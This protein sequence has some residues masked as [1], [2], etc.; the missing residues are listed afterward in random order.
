LFEIKQGETSMKRFRAISLLFVFFMLVSLQ[1]AEPLG[2]QSVSSKKLNL[3][4]QKIRSFIDA[5]MKIWGTPGAAVGIVKD[6][7]VILAEGFGKR[8]VEKNLP[9]TAKTRFI[10]GSTTKAF[11]TMAMGILVD[12][13]KLDWDKPVVQ[14]I[15]QFKLMNEY[16]TLHVTP[17]DLATHRT[18]LPR[19]DM[20]WANS[21]FSL[22]ELVESLQYL[23]PSRDFRT[24][25][26][27]NNLMYIAAGYLVGQVSGSSWEDFVR[28]RIFKPLAMMDSGCTVPELT[29][30]AEYSF[31][32]GREKDKLKVLPF[33][34]PTD[35]L[36]YGARASGSI[37]TTAEDM[38]KWMLLHLNNGASGGK[39][40]ISKANLL[41][42]HTPQIPMPWRLTEKSEAMFPSYGLGW[43]I[44]SYR[45]HYRVH[46]GGA[47]MGFFSYVSLFPYENLGIVVQVN[48]GGALPTIV[49]NYASDVLLR[50]EALDWNK[51]A[52]DQMKAAAAP[53]EKRIEGTSPAHKMEDYAGEYIHPAYGLLKVDVAGNK[54]LASFHGRSSPLEHWHFETFQIAESD[55]G[56]TKLT[57]QTNALGDV[58]S[59]SAPLES[60]VKEIVFQRSQQRK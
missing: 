6:G 26:Q 9:V 49:A 36:M 31:A 16:A 38:C 33:P 11:T 13:G 50:L 4:L 14:Y 15:P 34:L 48:L 46:H 47:T 5:S 10:L 52:Q 19:H 28:E 24:T 51:K 18:G 3:A 20:V 35:K 39:Q 8:D 60:A 59:V 44:D 23:E 12:D 22:Q 55:L 40:I 25:F 29:S 42:M 43:E 7:K 58:V 27:Y 17:R 21:P 30:A 54:L 57:F 45:D 1:V 41:Q 37:N 56:G 2:V 53:Q 32:Y